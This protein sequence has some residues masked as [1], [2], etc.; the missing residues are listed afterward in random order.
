MGGGTR[1]GAGSVHSREGLPGPGGRAFLRLRSCTP[2]QVGEGEMCQKS[3]DVTQFSK[4]KRNVLLNAEVKK[5]MF[6]DNNY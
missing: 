4:R 6:L 5:D 3:E 2:L 1:G